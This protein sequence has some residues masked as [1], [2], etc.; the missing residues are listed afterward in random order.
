V[1]GVILLVV[2]AVLLAIL[3]TFAVV[4]H[5]ALAR[6]ERSAQVAQ[7]ARG[8]VQYALAGSGEPVLVLHG[9]VGGWDQGMMLGLDLFGPHD[10]WS[11]Y[12]SVFSHES[13][14]R[15]LRVQIVAPSRAG[16]LAT[17]L[18]AGRTVADAADACA[19]L[20]DSLAVRKVLVVGVSG[21]G[22]TALQF[23]LRHPDRI[24]GLLLVAAITKHHRQP[25]RT[26]DSPAGRL[27]F[28]DAFGPV[29]DFI[30]WA[31]LGLS[32]LATRRFVRMV[33]RTCEVGDAAHFRDRVASILRCPEQLRWLRGLC[34]SIFPLSPR[35]AGLANDL[36]QFA[37]LDESPAEYAR[38]ACPTLIM[39]GRLDGNV[40]IE[41]ANWVA[42][43]VPG[44]QL[45]VIESCGHMLWM[46][47][48]APRLRLAAQQFVRRTRR[49][50]PTGAEVP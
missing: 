1:T 5:G 27:I 6:L 38:I 43:A 46:S 30:V 48:E 8:L 28:A 7:T 18:S 26:T 39:H 13:A 3:V 2:A 47:D 50:E 31:G 34:G 29:L 14:A 35:K 49:A 36:A 4:R 32:H 45:E 42:S 11:T 41:H 37:G 9:G 23:A 20:L 21:G 12:D 24:R 15:D 22:P 25:G 10:R 44:A 16:Y 33:L 40:P 17:P 19:A